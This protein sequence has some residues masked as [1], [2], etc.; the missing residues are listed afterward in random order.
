VPGK[1]GFEELDFSHAA[2]VAGS[3]GHTSAGVSQSF[4]ILLWIRAR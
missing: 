4:A 2:R 3:T 1:G